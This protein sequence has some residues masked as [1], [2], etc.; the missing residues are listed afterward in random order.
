L[1]FRN[2]FP[3][4]R[5]CVYHQIRFDDDLANKAVEKRID[6]Y[7]KLSDDFRKIAVQ[8]FLALQDRSLRKRPSTG[9][10]LVWL[11]VLALMVGTYPERLDQD[12]SKLSYRGVL[13]KDHQDIGELYLF[14]LREH[15]ERLLRSAKIA[16]MQ[17]PYSIEEMTRHTLELI[18]V[19]NLRE[20][21]HARIILFVDS[22]D[23]GLYSTAPIGVLLAAM[24]LG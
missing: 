22:I 9:E 21:I 20:D 23:G 14:R 12:L 10:L 18:R 7:A 2:A 6:E 15:L 13:L 8:R 19:N 11:R 5:R 1:T 3:F 16:Q 17:C 24:P 4:L